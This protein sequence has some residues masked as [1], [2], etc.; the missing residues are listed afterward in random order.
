MQKLPLIGVL[1]VLIGS[2]AAVSASTRTR[3]HA[4]KR[5]PS[6]RASN[7]KVQAQ[8]PADS[9]HAR[10]RGELSLPDPRCTPGA[11]SPAVKQSNLR[12]TICRSG[13]SRSVRPSESITEREKLASMAAYGD[14]DSP[15]HYE[16][17]HLVSLE[18]GGATNDARNLWPE[19]GAT[20][21][22]KDRLEDRLHALVC[23]GSVTLASAQTQV[24]HNWVKAYRRYVGVTPSS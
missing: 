10:G 9:C 8:P 14:S 21:N 19:P 23:D 15:R 2:A 18:L 13:Y 3:Q 24:A 17:D 6:S 16:Y 11:I 7:H 22:V 4:P 20:P 5:L 1:L 12:R